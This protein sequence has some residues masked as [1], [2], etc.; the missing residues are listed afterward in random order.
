MSTGSTA[1]VPRGVTTSVDRFITVLG[2]REKVNGAAGL[3]VIAEDERSHPGW[4]S[5]EQLRPGH[6]C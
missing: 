1:S 4:G 6:R 3:R 2:G 5:V